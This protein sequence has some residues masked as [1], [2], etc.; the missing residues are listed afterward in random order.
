M[1][2]VKI[3][4]IIWLLYAPPDWWYADLAFWEVNRLS[5][6]RFITFRRVVAAIWVGLA[7]M[8][9]GQGY[10]SL[11]DRAEHSQNQVHFANPLAGDVKVCGGTEDPCSHHHDDHGT[12]DAAHDHGAASTAGHAHGDATMV[13]LVAQIFVLMP[14]Q[15]YS[16]RCASPLAKFVS[17]NPRG[18][19]H[20]P[21]V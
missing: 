8:L 3:L 19:D 7:V 15:L 16:E 14:C 5:W 2:K 11:K 20:P 9:S 10:I 4:L 13:L 21:K 17:F 12:Q 6:Q 1:A 18:P